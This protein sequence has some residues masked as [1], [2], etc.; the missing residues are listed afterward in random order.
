MPTIIRR[1]ILANF[2]LILTLF[3]SNSSFAATEVSSPAD[4]TATIPA[5][6]P[7]EDFEV[8]T[9]PILLRPIDGA[10]TG[11]PRPELVWRQAT[12]PNSNTIY[13]IVYI[14]GVATYLSVSDSG[15]SLQ[16]NYSSRLESGEIR[17]LPSQDFP[18]GEYDWYVIASDLSGNKTQ[19]ATWHFTIDTTPPY[20]L[21]TDIDNHNDLELDSRNPA[22]VPD[23]LIYEIRGP[24]DIYFIIETEPYATIQIQFLDENG[25]LVAITSY[26]TGENGIAMPFQYLESG[27]YRV[28]IV[29]IDKARNTAALPEFKLNITVTEIIIPGIPGI[30]EPKVVVIPPLPSLPATISK[31]SA[32]PLLTYLVATIILAVILWILWNKRY[33]LLVLD[34]R[35]N[36]TDQATVFHSRPDAKDHVSGVLMTRRD[37]IKYSLVST[38]QGK[39]HIRKLGKYSTLTL[40]AGE[41]TL[42]LSVIQMPRNK[43]LTII[44]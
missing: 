10:E 3:S 11:D 44:L 38:D 5:I 27:I 30:T 1:T 33:N 25:T 29:A 39:L 7:P 28:Q 36:P 43:P 40:V 32:L 12:D 19:S 26:I 22:T 4:V 23:D 9:P 35:G 2:F 37:P 14:D 16:P 20:I 41:T 8:P 31:I 6:A 13:Y 34:I 18:D 15:N 21:V 24:K 17:L 42:V